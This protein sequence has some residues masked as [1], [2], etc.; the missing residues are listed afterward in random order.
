ME[1]VGPQSVLHDRVGTP[2]VPADVDECALGDI[3][4]FGSC[5]N[6]PGM[7]RCM[8]DNGYE[9]DQSGSNCAGVRST[10]LR[11]GVQDTIGPLSIL[12]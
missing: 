8:C 5:E 1:W 12:A 11:L 3:C 4:M 7:F 2:G 9:Q 10:E 6:L